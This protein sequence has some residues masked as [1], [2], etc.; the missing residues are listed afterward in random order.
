MSQGGKES[1]KKKKGGLLM[2]SLEKRGRVEFR[3][4]G[5]GISKKEGQPGGVEFCDWGQQPAKA[6]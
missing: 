4:G 1:G 5:R 2:Y 6:E 3:G